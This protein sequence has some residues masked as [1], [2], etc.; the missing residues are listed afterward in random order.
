MAFVKGKSGNPTGRP[1]GTPDKV[2][3]EARD[4]SRSIFDK[5][6][7]ERVSKQARAG[8]L[9]PKIEALLLQYA[10]GAP[11]QQHE[12]SGITVNIGFLSK[13]AETPAIEAP[14]VEVKGLPSVEHEPV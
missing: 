8:E 14:A 5:A 10:Y 7:W 6:Y 1:K 13:G 9:N 2:S 4:L 12:H 11:V 3:K